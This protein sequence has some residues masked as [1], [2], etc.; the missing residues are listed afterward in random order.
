MELSTRMPCSPMRI[1]N[2]V[3]SRTRWYMN[4]R[5]IY[6]KYRHHSMIPPATYIRNL[7]LAQRV[8]NVKGCIIECGVWRGGMIAGIAEVLGPDRDYL[9]FDSFEGMPR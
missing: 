8:Q 9:L 3:R 1:Y 2:G 4:R 6:E 5:R 7:E